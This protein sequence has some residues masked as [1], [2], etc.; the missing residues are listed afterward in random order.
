MTNGGHINDGVHQKE[1]AELQ[2]WQTLQIA[3]MSILT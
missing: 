3:F 2:A 1:T